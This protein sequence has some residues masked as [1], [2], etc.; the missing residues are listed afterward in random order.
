MVELRSG[1]GAG[2]LLASLMDEATGR[3][4]VGTDEDWRDFRTDELGLVRGWLPLRG[5]EPAFRWGY[6]PIGRWGG[7]KAGSPR[8]LLGE[9]VGP[10]LPAAAMRPLSLPA[11]LGDGRSPGSPILY[12]WGRTV[13]GFLTL[14]LAGG[15][16]P[17]LRP[18]VRRG[19][20][21]ARSADRPSHRRRPDRAGTARLDGRAPAPLPLRAAGGAGGA[22]RGPGATGA[23]GGACVSRGRWR[24]G[25]RIQGAAATNAGGGRSLEQT[26][27]LPGRRW[28]E[29][30]LARAC[31]GRVL[32]GHRGD[33]L[34]RPLARTSSRISCGETRRSCG[35]PAP[36][37]P[38]AAARPHPRQQQEQGSVSLPSLRSESTGLPR[39]ALAGGEVE[40]V[41]DELEAD[42]E[43]RP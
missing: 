12:D 19:E 9:G 3:Q 2:G 10:R 31:G 16:G 37:R 39:L 20:E 13:E 27:E 18:A 17:G 22:G 40:Q 32:L 33:L 41:V 35:P 8:P 11:S 14:E 4:I 6:P 36:A 42:A 1:R 43:R 34:E 24:T 23:G 38:A 29:R 5:G 7:Q 28:A 25:F 26:P 21:P 30:T 15:Q